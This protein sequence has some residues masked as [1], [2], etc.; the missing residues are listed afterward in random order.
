M[1]YVESKLTM[2]SNILPRKLT[3][4]WILALTLL[5][6]LALLCFSLPITQILSGAHSYYIDNPFHVY[7]IELGKSLLQHGHLLGYD[8]FLGAGHLGGM[9]DN[10]SARLPVFVAALLPAVPTGVVYSLYVL[11]CALI[12][13]LA[14]VWL[15]RLLRWPAWHSA[16]AA[17]LGLA[18]WWIGALHWFHTAGMVSYVCGSYLGLPYA[19]WVW[20]LCSAG[21]RPGAARLAGAGI[22]GGL[23]MWLHP[24]FPILVG[25]LFVGFG[26]ADFRA[27]SVRRVGLRGA[28]IAT[29]ALLVN[30]PWLIAMLGNHD[31]GANPLALHPFQKEIGLQVALK[32]ALGL[33]TGMGSFCN[34]LLLAACLA[35]LYF[36]RGE[37]RRR[38][39]PFVIAGVLLLLF[40]AFG[41]LSAAL[42]QLQPNRFVAP[43]FLLIAM[44]AAYCA[45]E[46]LPWL[47]RDGWSKGRLAGIAV[48]ALLCLYTGREMVREAMAGPHGHYGKTPPELSG[49]PPLVAQLEAWISA[50]TTPDGRILFETSLARIHGGGHVAGLIALQTDREF[51]GAGYPYSLPAVSFWD[52][53]A[54]GRPIQQLSTAELA[55][56]LDLYNVGWVIAHTPQLQKAMEALPS[57]SAAAQFG[58]VRIYK[59]DR[60]LSFIA[61][62]EGRIASRGFNQ[63]H[64]S[65]AGGVSVILK[66][67]WL[68]GLVASPAASIEPVQLAPGFPPFIRVRNPPDDFTLSLH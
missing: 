63:I 35:G 68:P 44:G 58:T 2:T 3:T 53:V 10:G 67:H 1:D 37:P 54:F 50:N 22:L 34:P 33:W 51:M 65:G 19:A 18:L 66:Y 49:A 21:H 39:L 56:G 25:L 12:G 55:Q 46:Y 27:A 48:A 42:A 31:I 7:Q 43:A 17:A 38:L 64:V 28:V 62:G 41:A 30:L 40:A 20:Q 23:G 8:P 11:V 5:V 9:S 15:G 60:P 52:R 32:P 61:E 26:V 29:I 13:P 45:G 36:M 14:V 24:L 6:Q 57:A 47:G 59:I 16:M 4:L